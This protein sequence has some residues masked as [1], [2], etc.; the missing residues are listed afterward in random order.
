MLPLWT[1]DPFQ[2]SI[3]D[4]VKWFIRDHEP[5]WIR[6]CRERRMEAAWEWKLALAEAGWEWAVVIPPTEDPYFDPDLDF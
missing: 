2:L 6:R 5:Q 3:L 4:H 1:D